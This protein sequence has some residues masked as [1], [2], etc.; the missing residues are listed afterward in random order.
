MRPRGGMDAIT[1]VVSQLTPPTNTFE[2]LSCESWRTTL[3]GAA[4]AEE[5]GAATLLPL[6]DTEV[7]VS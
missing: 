5:G 7:V 3:T 6:D 4:G 1:C 2:G